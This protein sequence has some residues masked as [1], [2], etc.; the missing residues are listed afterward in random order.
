MR[1]VLAILG[2]FAFAT[3]LSGA[4]MLGFLLQTDRLNDEKMFQIMALLHDVDTSPEQTDSE[5]NIVTETPNEEPSMAEIQRIREI[6][7][8][9]LE[10]KQNAIDRGKSEFEHL[11]VQL[12]E[13]SNR[14]D[15]LASEL[16]ERVRQESELTKQE[17]LANV[18]RDLSS[19]KPDEAKLLLIKILESGGADPVEQQQAMDDVIRLMGAMSSDTLTNILKK[20]KTPKELDDLHRIHQE[21]LKGGPKQ[22]VF[23]EV[24]N[25]IKNRDYTL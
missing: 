23:E 19:I 7:L 16:E 9:N 8:R 15:G 5:E 6:E 12:T 11:L 1:F 22:K 17:S 20:F 25:Q 18:V 21:M 2:Y 24:F 3:V 14:F 10:V 13:A 4:V